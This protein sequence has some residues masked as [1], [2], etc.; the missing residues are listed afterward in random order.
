LTERGTLP[1]TAKRETDTFFLSFHELY[2]AYTNICGFV[3]TLTPKQKIL[4]DNFFNPSLKI[5]TKQQQNKETT[6]E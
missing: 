1:C 3:S 4:H 2:L 6:S 5:V